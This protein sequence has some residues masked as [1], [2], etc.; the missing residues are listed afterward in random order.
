MIGKV[1]SHDNISSLNALRKLRGM[2][3]SHGYLSHNGN[4]SIEKDDVP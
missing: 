2:K 4:I 3:E 1:V